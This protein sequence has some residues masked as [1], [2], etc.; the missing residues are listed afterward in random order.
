MSHHQSLQEGQRCFLLDKVK[1]GELRD[2]GA[3]AAP[4]FLCRRSS[5][6]KCEQVTCFEAVAHGK[7]S[8]SSRIGWL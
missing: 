4:A 6:W 8:V 7:P 3:M 2:P 1:K 5:G